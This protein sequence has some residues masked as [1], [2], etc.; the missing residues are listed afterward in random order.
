[1]STKGAQQA[2][3]GSMKRWQKVE[4]AAVSSTTQLQEQTA[5]P[6]I[7]LVMEI[8]Q[9]DSEM[10]HRVQ[11]MIIDSLEKEALSLT[12]DELG[13][14]WGQIQQHLQIEKDTIQLAGV[15]LE[16]IEG[17]KG[18]VLQR[19]LLE[20]LLKDEQKHE[21]LLDDLEGIKKGMYPYG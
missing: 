16:A 2:L 5:N 7:R 19:Y 21:A 17:K 10:H 3:V 11:Q 1:M 9:R 4:D 12:P 18:M 8:I 15:A 6:L 20:Y 14:V 13:E